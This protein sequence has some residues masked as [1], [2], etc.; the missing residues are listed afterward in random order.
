MRFLVDKVALGQV[1][2]GAPCFCSVRIVPSMLRINFHLNV[3][4]LRRTTRRSLETIKQ[5]NSLSDI[6][7][8]IFTV[9]QAP[10][11]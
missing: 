1:F 10:Y 4:I 3:T 8:S 2:L 9:F 6:W 5:R 11:V 7:K